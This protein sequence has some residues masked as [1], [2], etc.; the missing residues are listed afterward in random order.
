MASGRV[1]LVLGASGQ[2]GRECAAAFAARGFRVVG[3]RASRPVEGL[4]PLD[5][6]DDGALRTLIRDVRPNVCVLASAL[7][8]VDRCE[9]EPALAEALNA[10]APGIA[11]EACREVAARLVHLS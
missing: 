6:R 8:N 4:V 5:L 2:V 7:T 1:A 9:E 3:T 10:R 11:A